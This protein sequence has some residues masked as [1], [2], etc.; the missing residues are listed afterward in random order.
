MEGCKATAP[1]EYDLQGDQQPIQSQEYFA[2]RQSLF[3][4]F[5]WVELGL[6]CRSMLWA[7]GKSGEN[8]STF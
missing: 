5:A 1:V 8:T 4:S 6:A 3:S 7:G 2:K